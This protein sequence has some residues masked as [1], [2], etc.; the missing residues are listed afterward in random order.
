MKTIVTNE[1]ADP[2]SMFSFVATKLTETWL[3]DVPDNE[4][5]LRWRNVVMADAL[6]AKTQEESKI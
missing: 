6:E 3:C 5:V 2:R 4:A 1:G